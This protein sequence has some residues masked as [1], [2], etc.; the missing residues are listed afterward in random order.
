MARIIPQGKVVTYTN[1]FYNGPSIEA[2]RYLSPNTLVFM[3]ITEDFNIIPDEIYNMKSINTLIIRNCGLRHLPNKI[4]QLNLIQIDLSNNNFTEIPK[5]LLQIPSLLTINLDM[6][7][8]SC[9]DLSLDYGNIQISLQNQQVHELPL[10]GKFINL[11]AQTATNYNIIYGNNDN[12]TIGP[13]PSFLNENSSTVVNC[14]RSVI[15]YTHRGDRL[16]NSSLRTKQ[17][18]FEFVSLANS[19]Y[20]G[21][22]FTK[23]LPI[24]S[25]LFRG[26]DPDII[27]NYI[28][29]A[30]VH[31]YGFSSFSFSL[32]VARSFSDHILLWN[33][34][35]PNI[36][37]IYFDKHLGLSYYDEKEF[38]VG[39][40][41]KF[42]ITDII[43][44]LDK[45]YYIIEFTEYELNYYN[46][47][48][49]YNITDLVTNLLNM[50]SPY[51]GVILNKILIL[52]SQYDNINECNVRF[53]LQGI[54]FLHSKNLYI[55]IYYKI[56][57][58]IIVDK[59]ISFVNYDSSLYIP[60][61]I[62]LIVK[63]QPPIS[64]GNL[65]GL[66]SLLKSRE[67]VS[68]IGFDKI[69]HHISYIDSSLL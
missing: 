63:N 1:F 62:T 26:I 68:W 9:L 12:F 47:L 66:Y 69:N 13:S 7:S 67:L 3:N 49:Y 28:V 54:S 11:Y 38:L 36:N 41:L 22:S 25:Y 24:G 18:P 44:Y 29:G 21:K 60:G 52:Q 20:N 64:N 42:V 2:L 4:S 6:N 59:N 55:D 14:C 31:D 35:S 46:N 56:L 5:I 34:N 8:I 45:Y 33:I 30:T 58:S 57:Q 17:L 61:N 19:I 16:L 48:H 37:G 40:G 53:K 15:D 27:T 10:T 43:E 50:S 39:P 23:P 51:D 32:E 65:H